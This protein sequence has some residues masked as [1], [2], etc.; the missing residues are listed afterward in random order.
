MATAA[1]VAT[2]APSPSAFSPYPPPAKN[3]SD[4]ND[5]PDALLSQQDF[6]WKL[7]QSLKE[8]GVTD[9]MKVCTPKRS[10]WVQGI[11]AAIHC[12][13]MVLNRLT[14]ISISMQGQME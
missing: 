11:G 12:T 5:I 9:R 1:S 2:S 6:K 8:T 10:I 13:V 14:E 4:N 7:Y 3:A